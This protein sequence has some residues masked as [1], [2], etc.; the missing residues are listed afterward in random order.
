MRAVQPAQALP[1]RRS[2]AISCIVP[3]GG[4]PTSL[5]QQICDCEP[6]G[7]LIDAGVLGYRHWAVR[8]LRRAM[9]LALTAAPRRQRLRLAWFCVCSS[10]DDVLA[11][12]S[13]QAGLAW[14]ENAVGGRRNGCG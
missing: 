3:G 13:G 14:P 11:R 1:R 6:R 10:V 12:V 8:L 7:P 5:P 2:I 9:A 4:R